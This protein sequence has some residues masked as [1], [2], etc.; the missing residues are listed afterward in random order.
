MSNHFMGIN[1]YDYS[2]EKIKVCFIIADK[3]NARTVLLNTGIIFD[4]FEVEFGIVVELAVQQIPEVIR[5]LLSEKIAIY[6]VIP[7]YKI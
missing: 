4:T 3:E 2:S 7:K 1:P 6:A 5:N